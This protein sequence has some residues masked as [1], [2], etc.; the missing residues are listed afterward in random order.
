MNDMMKREKP[1]LIQG[2]IAKCVDGRWADSDGLPLPTELL[3]IGTTRALQCWKS[4][5]LSSN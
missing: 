3:V 4:T 5:P 1:R 2:V